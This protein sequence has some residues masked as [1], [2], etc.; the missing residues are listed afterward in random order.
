MFRGHFE[1]AVDDKGRV[2]VPIQLREALSGLQE[3]RIVAT[4]FRIGT[5]RCLDVYP[6]SAWL[7][8]ERS[9]LAKIRIDPRYVR[10]CNVYASGA[11][12]LL[13][14]LQGRVLLPPLLR[15]Y[16]GIARDVMITGDLDKFRIW[17]QQVWQRVFVECEDL[18]KDDEEFLA[19]LDLWPAKVVPS[20]VTEVI[21]RLGGIPMTAGMAG[22]SV[23]TLYEARRRGYF[24]DA[25]GCIRLARALAPGDPV[26]QLAWV[27]RLAGLS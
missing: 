7:R 6:F 13:L 16:A 21:E 9:L 18:V 24:L 15:E 26:A 1:Q 2:A 8:L 22:V 19:S 3:E 20:V 25:Q 17:D 23:E 12:E 5:H 4:K 27:E 14:D 10:F 11:H